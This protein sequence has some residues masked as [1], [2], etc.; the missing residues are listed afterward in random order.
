MTEK[1]ED[2]EVIDIINLPPTYIKGFKNPKLHK[3]WKEWKEMRTDQA[4]I[5]K[6]EDSQ[7]LRR[8]QYSLMR[9]RK[10]ANLPEMRIRTINQELKLLLLK[11]EKI[12]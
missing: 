5:I 1:K 8:F 7:E 11:L 4:I 6:C 12:N 10:N 2:V 9:R 3:A